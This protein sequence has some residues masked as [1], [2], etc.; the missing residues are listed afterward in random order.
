MAI[1]NV[2]FLAS[3]ALLSVSFPLVCK[4]ICYDK[5]QPAYRECWSDGKP[6]AACHVVRCAQDYKWFGWSCS[7]KSKMTPSTIPSPSPKYKRHARDCLGECLPRFKA[8]RVYRTV[9]CGDWCKKKRC[10]KFYPDYNLL[11]LGFKCVPVGTPIPTPR[12]I[13]WN[14]IEW[15]VHMERR[16]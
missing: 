14:R 15:L 8:W 13:L 10:H 3:A 9:R 11:Y 5:P 2:I 4:D 12:A 6:L 7:P 16:A 1:R